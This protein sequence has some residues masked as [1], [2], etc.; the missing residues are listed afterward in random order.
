M[1]KYFK[2]VKNLEELRKQYKTLLKKY[3]PDCGGD[4][5]ICKEIISEYERLFK[6]LEASDKYDRHDAEQTKAHNTKYSATVDAELRAAV[7]RIIRFE[8]L[9]IEIIGYW[10]YVTGNTY[11]YKEE[12]KN[13]HYWYSPSKKCWFWG[14]SDSFEYNKKKRG[15]TM[16]RNRNKYGSEILETEGQQKIA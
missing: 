3:H 14:G 4:A 8:G 2:D 7:E 12:I 9:K 10:I 1:Y 13:A 15:H 11:P 16:E 6:E 5:E